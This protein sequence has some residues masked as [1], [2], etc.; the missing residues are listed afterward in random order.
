METVQRIISDRAKRSLRIPAL[1]GKGDA[2]NLR[3]IVALF[4]ILFSFVCSNS[5]GDSS[6]KYEYSD[7]IWRKNE[8]DEILKIKE[9]IGGRYWVIENDFI[10]F[11]DSPDIMAKRFHMT[12]TESFVVQDWVPSEHS[13]SKITTIEGISHEKYLS[14]YKIIFESGKTAYIQASELDGSALRAKYIKTEDPKV[15]DEKNRQEVTDLLK[16]IGIAK[17]QSLWLK[18]PR[19]GLPGLTKIILNNYELKD[20]KYL[21]SIKFY[22]EAGNRDV[23]IE[24]ICYGQ[25]KN[26]ISEIRDAVHVNDP[27][28]V[29]SKWGK[30]VLTA[31]KE[32]NVFIGMTKEQTRASW[33]LPQEINKSGG[34]W[35][36]HEQ[37][38]YGDFGPYLYFENNKLTSWQD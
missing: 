36:I 34:E 21:P 5:F 15:T 27:S 7:D 31:I 11:Y 19:S 22:V 30:R 12:S 10:R 17:G 20:D 23:E 24:F 9:K 2:M 4:I 8:D 33:G 6:N 18:Y 1:S 38:I 3:L 32:G 26:A 29:V 25:P 16:E 13:T 28:A 14:F 35:G 37:W